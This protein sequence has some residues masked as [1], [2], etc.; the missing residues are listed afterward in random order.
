MQIA[1]EFHKWWNQN[2]MRRFF[3]DGVAIAGN[4]VVSRGDLSLNGLSFGLMMD[5]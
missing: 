2:Q 1:Y 5:F 4:D 3:D